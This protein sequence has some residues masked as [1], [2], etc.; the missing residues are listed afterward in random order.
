MGPCERFPVGEGGKKR[1][2]EKFFYKSAL[3]GLTAPVRAL[4]VRRTSTATAQILS[5]CFLGAVSSVGRATD[6]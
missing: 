3:K 5:R 1:G 6:F 2:G 4:M